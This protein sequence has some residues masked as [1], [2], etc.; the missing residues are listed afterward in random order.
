[1]LDMLL[2]LAAVSPQAFLLFRLGWRPYFARSLD[3]FFDRDYVIMITVCEFELLGIGGGGRRKARYNGYEGGRVYIVLCGL[4]FGLWR[5]PYRSR[6]SADYMAD[7][8]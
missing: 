7:S 3:C 4:I 8:R 5:D 1:M 6:N 2:F